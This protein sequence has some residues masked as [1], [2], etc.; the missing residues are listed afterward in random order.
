MSIRGWC[1][2]TY[3]KNKEAGQALAASEDHAIVYSVYKLSLQLPTDW[4]IAACEKQ[5]I[6]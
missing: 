3:R 5:S 1:Q 6:N 2:Q 4:A